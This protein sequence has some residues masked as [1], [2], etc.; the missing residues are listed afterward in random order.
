V[1]RASKELLELKAK[2][3]RRD[4]PAQRDGQ[5]LKARQDQ[6]DL[7]DLLALLDLQVPLDLLALLLPI[8]RGHRS[9][10]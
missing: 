9:S 5:G 1:K 8:L 7:L 6:R 4:R 10:G 2:G 3:A